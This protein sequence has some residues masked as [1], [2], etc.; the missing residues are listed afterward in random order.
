MQDRHAH[1]SLALEISSTLQA[2]LPMALIAAAPTSRLTRATQT[3]DQGAVDSSP[4]TIK[5]VRVSLAK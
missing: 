4:C 1:L 5:L 2:H 3:F